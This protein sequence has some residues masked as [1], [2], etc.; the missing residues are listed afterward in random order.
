M[1]PTYRKSWARNLLMCSDL[2]L[3]KQSR[4]NKGS[5]KAA[6]LKS[7]YLLLIYYCYYGFEM[8][9]QPILFKISAAILNFGRNRKRCLSGKP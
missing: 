2:T 4:S 8:S 6:K 3:G 9:N 7:A 1:K 5:Q